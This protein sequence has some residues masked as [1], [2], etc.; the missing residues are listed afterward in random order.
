MN[1][2]EKKGLYPQQI[3][4]W[5]QA[6]ITG[7][8]QAG[9]QSRQEKKQ[10][11]QDRKRIQRL[12]SEIRRKDKALAE[13]AA[14]LVLSKKLDALLRDRQRG[15]LTPVAERQQ[16]LAWFDETTA[17]GVARWKAAEQLAV[18]LKTLNRWR[19]DNG[20]VLSDKRP[21]S[22]R[23]APPNKLTE[24]E[25]QRILAVCNEPENGSLPP[26]QIV[27]AL[28]DKGEY[29]ASESSFYRVLKKHGQLHHRG[30]SRRR[31]T[32]NK[33]TTH[34]ASGSN[35]VWCWDISYVPSR[36]RGQ[37]WYLYLVLD[38]YSRKVVAWEIHDKE[39]VELASALISRVVVAEKCS[40]K[41]V[42][43]HSD[44]GAPMTSHTLQAKLVE[45]GITPSHSRPRVSND[46][47]FAESV[48]KTVKYC[49]QW[50]SQGFLSLE[51]SRKWMLAFVRF[52][53]Q[54]HRHSGI[55]FVTPE[56]RHEGQDRR[57]LES[58]KQVYRKA[59]EKNP[60]RW[61]GKLRNWEPIKSV[62]LNPER[63]ENSGCLNQAA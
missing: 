29:I 63:E 46:N 21:E 60:L 34:V 26:S 24:E 5:K 59:R 3:H 33:P 36:V 31:S 40:K 16:L 58:R 53:N 6:C 48:F 43:L 51:E 41:P 39:S 45:L 38:I 55:R 35:Q 50:P 27:P 56:Q 23:V 1:I 20:T 7:A 37:F 44:N 8:N 11:Q 15:Q 57:I 4:E 14:L 49:P 9:E 22:I 18:S 62:A 2:V 42:V 61:S 47:A 13:T 12:E 17:E 32:S 28:A 52:Y 54:K 19:D 30:R 25:E 10:A